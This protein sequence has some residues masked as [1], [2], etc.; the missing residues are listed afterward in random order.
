MHFNIKH[1]PVNW[2]DGM[3]VSKKHFMQEQDA[4]TDSLRDV[5]VLGLT[6]FNFGL[7][8]DTLTKND[9]LNIEINQER[10]ELFLCRAVTRAGARI[11]LVD[12]IPGK[13]R[14]AVSDLTGDG[15]IPN[16][17]E[18]YIVLKVNPFKRQ[19]VGQADPSENPIRQPN[20]IPTY[21]LELVDPRQINTPEF[22]AYAIPIAKIA[23]GYNG[24]ERVENY[25]PP[26]TSVMA[27]PDLFQAY[28]R[29]SSKVRVI[30]SNLLEIAKKIQHKRRSNETTILADDIFYVCE[31][32]MHFI[33]NNANDHRLLHPHR[34]PI[35]MIA[36]FA[37]MASSL[38]TTV[39]LLRSKDGMLEY[40]R[41]YLNIQYGQFEKTLEQMAN[42]TYNHFDIRQSIDEVN[43]FVDMIEELFDKLKA[44]DYRELAKHDP[45]RSTTFSGNRNIQSTIQTNKDPNPSIRIKS[46]KKED[47]AG[48]GWG[49]T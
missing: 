2:V 28:Q 25:I 30:E 17:S 37:N 6:D 32:L 34:P 31:K 9:A 13:L 38:K 19:A 3:K 35:H 16:A 7:L 4:Y 21:S 43:A 12:Y 46:N 11:E 29:L 5:T 23:G 40:F 39:A 22:A 26:C 44:L 8:P 1:L 27:H 15:Q 24:L 48:G 18:W 33:A 10:V 47:N 36:Y 42:F 14:M 41:H 20:S 49:V 45:V